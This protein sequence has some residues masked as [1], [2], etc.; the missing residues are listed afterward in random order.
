MVPGTRM[1]TAGNVRR[2]KASSIKIA[3][4]KI[5]TSKNNMYIYLFNWL[6]RLMFLKIL[7]FCC[8]FYFVFF[9]ITYLTFSRTGCCYQPRLIL[10][11]CRGN[12]LSITNSPAVCLTVTCRVYHRHEVADK[13]CFDYYYCC[14]YY[15]CY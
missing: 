6:N 10:Q 9:L 13:R 14:Y 3:N 11:M 1:V 4:K 12:G 2:G 15:Y 5:N 8:F 7:K